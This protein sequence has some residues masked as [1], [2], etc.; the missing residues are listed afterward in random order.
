LAY[1]NQENS[2]EYPCQ[3]VNRYQCPYER[4]TNKENREAD[5]NVGETNSYFVE[6]LFRLQKMAFIVEIAL[7]KARKDDSKIQ[8]R[9]KQDLLHALTDRDTF[10]KILHQAD[11]TLKSI[12]YLR[13]ISTRQDTYIADYFMRLRNK[14]ALEELR[15]Y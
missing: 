15:F 13:E 9:D 11:D 12:E 3:V 10:V 4:T 5:N 14:I 8:I 1:G 2:I 6:D 7:A